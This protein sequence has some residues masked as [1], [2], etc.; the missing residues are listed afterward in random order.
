[1]T[2]PR[3]PHEAYIINGQWAF[4]PHPALAG[5]W[6]RVHPCVAAVP[7]PQCNSVEGEPCRWHRGKYGQS[8]HI[9]RQH[10]PHYRSE[11]IRHRKTIKY[12]RACYVADHNEMDLQV[13]EVELRPRFKT[14]RFPAR[15]S[16]GAAS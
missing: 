11:M 1:V 14:T 6:L 3:G 16:S 4:I 10:R 15:T 12:D 2:R 9:V 13:A 7:C 5:I 8:H